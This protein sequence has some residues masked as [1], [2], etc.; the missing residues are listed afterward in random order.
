MRLYAESEAR[1]WWRCGLQKRD[2]SS[3][4]RKGWGLVGGLW[5]RPVCQAEA[6]LRQTCAAPRIE[7]FLSLPWA[8]HH[9]SGDP[10]AHGSSAGDAAMK[11]GE[12][13]LEAAE[14]VQTSYEIHLMTVALAWGMRAL[15]GQELWLRGVIIGTPRHLERGRQK[16]EREE[17]CS[18]K[19]FLSLF[20]SLY[21]DLS[22]SPTWPQTD[23]FSDDT[24]VLTQSYRLV[25]SFA[26][27]H[28]LPGSWM[29][30][31]LNLPQAGR[32]SA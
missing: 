6:L 16:G 3:C 13:R 11:P 4:L 30:R 12:E 22:A 31:Q 18:S 1:G 26:N 10:S 17:F 20:L 28:V 25:R 15:Q 2:W 14:F 32:L 23:W 19:P 21:L 9:P 27:Q 7:F 8:L 29:S 5:K 24:N